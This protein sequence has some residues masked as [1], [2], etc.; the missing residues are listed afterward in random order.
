[1]LEYLHLPAP[2]ILRR[3][4][5]FRNVAEHDLTPPNADAVADFVD[6]VSLFLDSTWWY[7][8]RFADEVTYYA[9]PEGYL[10]YWH[11]SFDRNRAQF[12]ITTYFLDDHTECESG[13][14][15]VD[16]RQ[17]LPYL[18]E[19]LALLSGRMLF[20]VGSGSDSTDVFSL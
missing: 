9:D 10:V 11:A 5:T 12:T 3:L 13:T 2:R 1:L 4:N 15:G 8:H 20:D 6:A 18:R 16:D 7:I 17:Y 14:L 19:Y